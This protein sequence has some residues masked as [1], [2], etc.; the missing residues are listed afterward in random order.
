[1]AKWSEFLSFRRK[2]WSG[3]VCSKDYKSR[4]KSKWHGQFKS[5][6]DFDDVFRQ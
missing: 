2:I 1:M 6:D 4:R 5:Y 3:Y